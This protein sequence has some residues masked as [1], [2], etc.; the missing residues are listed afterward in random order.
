[1]SLVW[2]TVDTAFALFVSLCKLA[3]LRHMPF[4]DSAGLSAA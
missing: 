4:V 1:M 2:E 3:R